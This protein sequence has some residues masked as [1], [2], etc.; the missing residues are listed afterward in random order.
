ME[1][2]EVKV[3][4]LCSFGRNEWDQTPCRVVKLNAVRCKVVTTEQRGKHLAGTIW[5][6]DYNI[7]NKLDAN[8][9]PILPA[10]KVKEPLTY[11]I[12]MPREDNL[13]MEAIF[14]IYCNLSPENLTCDGELPMS[15]VRQK[16]SELHRKLKYLTAALG[17]EVSEEDAYA[18]M[19]SKE[20]DEKVH[21]DETR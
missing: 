20:E 9:K 7:L 19:T 4:M 6:V 14:Q 3:G 5:N 15:R 1:R 21:S 8:G 13:I 16:A 10:P 18:W 17:Q 11:N 2:H 12:F